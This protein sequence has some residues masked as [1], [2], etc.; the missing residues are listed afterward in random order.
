VAV[1]TYHDPLVIEADLNDTTYGIHPSPAGQL[2]VAAFTR[3]ALLEQC[4][5]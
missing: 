4:R 1:G 5:K 3:T 2:T